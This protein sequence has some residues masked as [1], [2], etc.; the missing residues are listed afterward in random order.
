MINKVKILAKYFPRTL[1][2]F[3]ENWLPI[4]ISGSINCC[5]LK[6]L[7]CASVRELVGKLILWHQI[8]AL[9]RKAKSFRKKHLRLIKSKH[10]ER[11]TECAMLLSELQ[12]LFKPLHRFVGGQCVS[13]KWA[14]KWHSNYSTKGHRYITNGTQEEVCIVFYLFH[15]FAQEWSCWIYQWYMLSISIFKQSVSQVK[16]CVPW[17]GIRHCWQDS[18]WWCL[19]LWNDLTGG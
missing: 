18:Y 14:R 3:F 4:R 11:T 9:C 17:C 15:K 13:R 7:R 1:P 16:A 6:K 5:G 19:H 2:V 10:N 8:V 12:V